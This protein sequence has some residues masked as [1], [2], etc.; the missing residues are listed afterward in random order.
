MTK[1]FEKIDQEITK[2]KVITPKKKPV[3]W[4]EPK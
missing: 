1:E 2:E 4:E 3:N